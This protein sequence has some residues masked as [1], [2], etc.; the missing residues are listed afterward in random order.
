[1]LTPR[2]VETLTTLIKIMGGSKTSAGSF[3]RTLEMMN[4][5]V[6]FRILCPSYLT[7]TEGYGTVAAPAG[8]AQIKT[9]L[10]SPFDIAGAQRVKIRYGPYK[11]PNMNK[12]NMIGATGMLYNYPH[13][14]IQK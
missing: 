7:V 2:T 13:R 3:P 6:N 14:N 5:K 12:K 9:V 8:A 11:V 4:R 1:M 10:K